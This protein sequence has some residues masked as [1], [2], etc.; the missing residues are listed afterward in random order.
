MS[1][2]CFMIELGCSSRHERNLGDHLEEIVCRSAMPDDDNPAPFPSD[3]GGHKKHQ[4]SINC[5]RYQHDQ[6]DRISRTF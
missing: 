6:M 3:S 4:Y 1:A 5:R 2:K